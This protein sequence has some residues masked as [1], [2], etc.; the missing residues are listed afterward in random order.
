[1]GALS[2][3][4]GCVSRLDH[5]GEDLASLASPPILDYIAGQLDGGWLSSRGLIVASPCF[6]DC[7]LASL[8]FLSLAL[9]AK[10]NMANNIYQG[11]IDPIASHVFGG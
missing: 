5:K 10:G 7:L 9:V 4:R 6:S 8:G 1:M 11:L 2:I 3:Q